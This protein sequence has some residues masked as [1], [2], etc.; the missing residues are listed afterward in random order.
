MGLEDNI[1]NILK[2]T[3]EI[4]QAL[5]A[6][7]NPAQITAG[8]ESSVNSLSTQL[9]ALQ[10]NFRADLA[11]VLHEAKKSSQEVTAG[12]GDSL[13]DLSMQLTVLQEKFRVDLESVLQEAKETAKGISPESI[14]AIARLPPV[15]ANLEEAFTTLSKT[16]EV[17]TKEMQ[18]DLKFIKVS[19]VEDVVGEVRKLS[20]ELNTTLTSS[21]R[22]TEEKYKAS[23]ESFTLIHEGQKNTESSLNALIENQ[24]DQLATVAELRDRVNAIIQVE[25]AALKDRITIYLESSVNELKTSVN[26]R[27]AIQD[28]SIR[29]V[30]ETTQQLTQAL[31]ALPQKLS[32]DINTAVETKI[33]KE[34][35]AM[36]KEMKKMTAFI[37]KAQRSTE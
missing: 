8:V 18:D 2:I 5:E 20:Q 12:V 22:S 9:I 15:L 24:T 14:E 30:T 11:T 19:Y 28:A 25:L 21:T 4:R 33:V 10:E 34:I 35:D 32:Q 13:N 7:E 16:L 29:K 3:N 27:L 17:T 6:F 31:A 23:V 1:N 37:I 36:K 26:E